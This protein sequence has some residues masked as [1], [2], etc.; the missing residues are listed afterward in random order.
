MANPVNTYDVIRTADGRFAVF[1]NGVHI[2]DYE[3]EQDA[4]AHCDRLRRQMQH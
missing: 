2:A 1:V 3:H 4:L